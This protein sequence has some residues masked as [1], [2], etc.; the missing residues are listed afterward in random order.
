VV[1]QFDPVRVEQR[2]GLRSFFRYEKN[3]GKSYTV[4]SVCVTENDR[5]ELSG[6]V[7]SVGGN[8]YT[9]S[10]ST[11]NERGRVVLIQ[12]GNHLSMSVMSS[13]GSARLT[14][15]ALG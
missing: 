7:V 10:V 1:A 14:L 9:G 3:S 15:S 2:S 12:H 4:L 13:M 5:Y 8:R 6:R 11:G